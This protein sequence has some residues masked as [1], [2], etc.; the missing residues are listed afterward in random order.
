[1]TLRLVSIL[2]GYAMPTGDQDRS[3]DDATVMTDDQ[4]SDC[5]FTND[6]KQDSVWETVQE[7]PAHTALDNS[8]VEWTCANSLDGCIDFGPKLITEP[9]PLLV[10]VQDGIIEFG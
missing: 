10:V 2:M 8:V 9:S 5:V 1:M 6:A 4:H 3:L 7:T